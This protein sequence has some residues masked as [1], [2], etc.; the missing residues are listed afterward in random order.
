MSRFWKSTRGWLPGVIISVAAIAAILYKVDLHQTV[1]RDT[2]GEIL[3]VGDRGRY[4]GG[5][6]AGAGDGLANPAA[7]KS[8]LPGCFFY[9][10]RRIPAEQCPA[11]PVG[12]IGAGFFA[13]QKDRA[14][15]YGCFTQHRG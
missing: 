15:L 1:E 2:I 6:A 4:R 9:R 14:G 3:A 7:G 8:L 5:M 11:F 12:R 13:R 10:K